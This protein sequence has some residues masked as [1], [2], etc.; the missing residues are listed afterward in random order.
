MRSQV[1]FSA[2]S[3][4]AGLPGCYVNVRRTGGLTLVLQQLKDHLELFLKRREFL[5]GSGFLYRRNVY[6]V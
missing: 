5:L 3:L 6:A 2:G 4:L 1:R